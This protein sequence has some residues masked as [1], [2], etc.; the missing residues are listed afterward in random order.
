MN[1]MAMLL[2]RMLN[3]TTTNRLGEIAEHIRCELISLNLS[4][5]EALYGA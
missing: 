5:R 2:S 4:L 1:G 3:E